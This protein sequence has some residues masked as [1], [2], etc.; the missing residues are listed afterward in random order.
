MPQSRAA[1]RLPFWGGLGLCVLVGAAH[2]ADLALSIDAESGFAVR[3]SAL[4]RCAVLAVAAALVWWLT[5]G[6]AVC[7]ARPQGSVN[8]LAI[9]MRFAGAAMAAL[10]VER[11]AAAWRLLAALL[12]YSPE[13]LDIW[14]IYAILTL[15]G[16]PGMAA[17]GLLALLAALWLLYL[18]PKA[19]AGGPLPGAGA[20]VLLLAWPFWLAL[21]RFLVDPAS[22]ERLPDTLRVL[23]AAALLLFAAALLRAVYVPDVPGGPGLCRA[24]LLCF[25]CGTCLELPQTLF[26]LFHGSGGT[27]EALTALVMGLLGLCG[28]AAAWLACGPAQTPAELALKPAAGSRMRVK[29]RQRAAGQSQ[30]PAQ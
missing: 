20:A 24:G 2:L 27:G 29:S 12:A 23:S 4:A 1:D 13:G 6:A 19:L 26:E 22:V 10:A 21:Q 30:G 5:R 25:L 7:F 8:A 9:A 3:G 17:T 14:H 15:P 28:L 11:F 16:I 18:G